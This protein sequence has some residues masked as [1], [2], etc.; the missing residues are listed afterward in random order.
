MGL[1]LCRCCCK[2]QCL[3]NRAGTNAAGADLDSLNR[4]VIN[5]LHLLQVGVPGGTGF[6]VGVAHV[7][8]GAGAFTADFTFSGH[9]SYLPC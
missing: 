2:L 6:V 8:A 7:V 5:G 9:G 3:G 1:R 4:A